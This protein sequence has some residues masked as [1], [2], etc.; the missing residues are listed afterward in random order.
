MSLISVDY[1]LPAWLSGE[2]L[3]LIGCANVAR[4]TRGG[5]TYDGRWGNVERKKQEG[6]QRRR[7][8]GSRIGWH[9]HPILL[10]LRNRE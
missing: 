7:D 4:T 3:R 9:L 1:T 6:P 5:V 2:G 10:I 8:G